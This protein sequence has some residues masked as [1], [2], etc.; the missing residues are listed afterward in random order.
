[1]M[2]E[3]YN[4]LPVLPR[5]LDPLNFW[6]GKPEEG[7]F[8]QTVKVVT[9]FLCIPE[10]SVPGEQLFSSAGKLISESRNNLQWL[11]SV[12]GE[13]GLNEIGLVEIGLQLR[14]K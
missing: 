3:E 14:T 4:I 13:I 1:M 8:L 6:R 11:Y 2:T 10:T 9:K 5:E 7:H 12:D